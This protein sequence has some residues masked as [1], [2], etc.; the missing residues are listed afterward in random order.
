MLSF[1]DINVDKHQT[2]LSFYE[3]QEKRPIPS[4]Y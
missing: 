3:C 1:I 4:K 2:I